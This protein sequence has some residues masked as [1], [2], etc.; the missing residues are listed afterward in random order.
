MVMFHMGGVDVLDQVHVELEKFKVFPNLPRDISHYC[1]FASE[2]YLTY[3]D[4]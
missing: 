2:L 1:G 3:I 4:L